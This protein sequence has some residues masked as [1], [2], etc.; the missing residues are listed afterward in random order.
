MRP[1]LR[2]LLVFTL[3]GLVPLPAWSVIIDTKDGKTVRGHLINEDALRLRV[4]LDGSAEEVV[5][6]RAEAKVVTRAVRPERLAALKPADPTAYVQY[7]G[8]LATQADDPEAR[9]TAVRLLVIAA[10]LDPARLGRP[11]LLAAS[12]LSRKPAEAKAFR[13]AAYLLDPLHDEATLQAPPVEATAGDVSRAAFLKALGLLR[14]GWTTAALEQ[15]GKDGAAALFA[16]VPGLMT[17]EEFAGLCR[18]HPDCPRCKAGREFCALCNG[19]GTP[20]CAGCKGLG[21][22]L[23]GQCQGRPRDVPLPARQ[24]Q[25]ILKLEAAGAVEPSGLAGRAGGPA[26]ADWSA[27]LRQGQDAPAPV[28]APGY[29]AGYDPRRCVYRDGEWVRP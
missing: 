2:P 12:E 7:A 11:S 20:N 8:E 21:F 10:H 1:W 27:L 6:P 15:A 5:I 23:C 19:K 14:R 24:K 17:Y 3:V 16:T 26:A 9:E 25:L 29:L 13:A 28:P 18:Q 22:T 4:R